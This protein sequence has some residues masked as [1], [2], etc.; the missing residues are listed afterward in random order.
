M[1]VS[2]CVPVE[3][4]TF[5]SGSRLFTARSLYLNLKLRWEIHNMFYCV[6]VVTVN[7]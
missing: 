7:E 1:D 5:P 2:K 4:P 3:I 6:L